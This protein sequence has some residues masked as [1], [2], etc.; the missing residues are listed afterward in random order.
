[1]ENYLNIKKTIVKIQKFIAK[2][3]SINDAQMEKIL[4]DANEEDLI[5]PAD[6]VIIRMAIWTGIE[7]VIHA[8]MKGNRGHG[9]AKGMTFCLPTRGEDNETIVT[10]QLHGFR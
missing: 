3:G 1:M 7:Y 10:E 2:K 4:G 5:S 8:R 9:F 6:A